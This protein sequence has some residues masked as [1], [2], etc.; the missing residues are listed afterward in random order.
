MTAAPT[1]PSAEALAFQSLITP[2][3]GGIA[4]RTLVK[5]S[6]GNVTLFAFDEGQGLTEHTTPF[7]ALA[8]VLEGLIVLTIGGKRVEAFPGTVVLMPGNVPHAVQ[9]EQASR[10]LLVMVKDQKTP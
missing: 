9:A 6:G 4:S 8:M 10:M 5:A 1:L 3:P 2:T 7:D